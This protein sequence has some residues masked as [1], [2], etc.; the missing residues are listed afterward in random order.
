M[1]LAGGSPRPKKPQF[2]PHICAQPRLAWG[3]CC[4][5]DTR[6]FETAARGFQLM[7]CH[8]ICQ[9]RLQPPTPQP[10]AWRG[11]IC[12]LAGKLC[13]AIAGW[14]APAA[15]PMP[16][17]W[18]HGRPGTAAG[19]AG[20]GGTPQS[21]ASPRAPMPHSGPCSPPP[22][23]P[24]RQHPGCLE[25]ELMSP[26]SQPRWVGQ[27][28]ARSHPQPWGAHRQA[29]PGSAGTPTASRAGLSQTKGGPEAN[30]KSGG[31]SLHGWS[32][33]IAEHP[34]GWATARCSLVP[35]ASPAALAPTS[36]RPL[37]CFIFPFCCLTVSTGHHCRRSS[38]PARMCLTSSP[39]QPSRSP[40]A[41]LQPLHGASS[42]AWLR[43][44]GCRRGCWSP[45]VP[46]ELPSRQPGHG[47]SWGP[48]RSCRD[49]GGK[50]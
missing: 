26:L 31:G 38:R 20:P 19:S 35:P 5:A 44:P 43:C 37:C 24:Q 16:V 39:W 7:L 40:L 2:K 49:P 17:R 8:K 10:P 42:S 23:T 36:F 13:P 30:C 3:S 41:T 4:C 1:D 18:G 11:G 29:A 33:T 47:A 15:C 6:P 9:S 50:K 48:A 27:E 14:G 22:Q 46:R 25:G 32:I 28:A 21:G 45:P 34:A 12:S